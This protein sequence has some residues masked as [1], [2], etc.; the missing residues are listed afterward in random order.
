MPTPSHQGPPTTVHLARGRDRAAEADLLAEVAGGRIGLE[1]VLADLNR[2]ARPAYYTRS[3]ASW[4]FA[5][6]ERDDRSLRWWPQGITS[7]ADAGTGTGEE[8]AGRRLLV[9]TAYSKRLG[10]LDKGAR[11]SVVDITD[12]AAIRYRHVLLVRAVLDDTGRL[13]LCPVRIHAGGAVWHGPFLHV[14]ATRKGLYTFHLDDI[15]RADRP[16]RPDL[17]GIQPDGAVAG[18]GHRYLLPL[19]LRQAARAPVGVEE[20]RYSF[21]S[22]DR[23]GDARALLVGEYARGPQTRRLAA[24]DLDPATQLPVADDHGISVPSAV[25]EGG[26]ER[27]QGAVG[28]GG[29]L[30]VTS[31]AGRRGRGDLWVGTPG[32]WERHP[33]VLPPGP[34]DLTYWPSRDELWTVTEYPG[35]RLVLALDRAR[36]T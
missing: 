23:H 3:A 21:L 9:T 36:F 17:L 25:S 22:L 29:R 34:E 32:A 13:E 14:A 27:M 20:L 28:V 35:R 7:S 8:Y 33:R 4:A 31:S 19:R 24:F 18:F 1:G 2:T 6:D 12:E 5:W 15:V 10:G 11:I 16:D 30:H 26:V